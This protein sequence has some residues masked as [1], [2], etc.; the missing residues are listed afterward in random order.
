MFK[1]IFAAESPGLCD[2]KSISFVLVS[3]DA[4]EGGG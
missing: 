3:I 4:E 1:A 2:K